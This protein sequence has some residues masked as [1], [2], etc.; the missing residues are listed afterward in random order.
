MKRSIISLPAAIIALLSVNFFMAS[1]N[2]DEDDNQ[3][4]P[5]ELPKLSIELEHLAG[6]AQL[7]LNTEYVNEMGDPFT[8]TL[9]KYY[10]TNIRLIRTDNSEYKIPGSYFLVNH[11][12]PASRVLEMDSLM[13][14]SYKAI[15]FMIGVDSLHNVSG[16]Q[17]GALDPVNGMFWDWNS[18]YIFLKLEGTSPAIPTSAQTFT[19]HIGGFAAPNSNIR[20]VTLTF[21]GE[22]MTLANSKHPELHLVVD[23][24]E[25]FKTPSTIDLATFSS[26]VVMPNMNATT[27]ANNYAD[28]FSFDH[29]H[30]D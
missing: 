16:A 28:M 10:F 6:S 15:K 1:C 4:V 13:A 5:V 7:Q 27:I 11:S 18:G 3:P 30:N 20:E 17:S 22:T 26:N 21:G 14:G 2:K 24:L 19:Y 12:D 9:F 25:I 23:V 8:P 29:L